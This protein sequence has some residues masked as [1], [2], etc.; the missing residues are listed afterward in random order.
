[1]PPTEK[2]LLDVACSP[3]P[4]MTIAPGCAGASGCELCCAAAGRLEAWSVEDVAEAGPD[5]TTG[6]SVSPT[7]G[8]M[9]PSASCS[10]TGFPVTQ[11]VKSSAATTAQP[12]LA[13]KGL[14][15]GPYRNATSPERRPRS[16]ARGRAAPS[17]PMPENRMS[18]QISRERYAPAPLRGACAMT[19]RRWT[20]VAERL[21]H[22][23]VT[24][25][26]SP[27]A[28]VFH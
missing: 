22:A 9:M 6:T 2:M 23:A 19:L 8:A 16:I 26:R 20:L 3:V 11:P 13:R 4:C 21:Q 7:S 27:G 15:E 12:T 10:G 14:D 25:K 17:W 18:G 28:G 5:A 24:R 1:M